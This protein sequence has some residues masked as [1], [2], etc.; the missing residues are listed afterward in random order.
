[1]D[2]GT[3]QLIQYTARQNELL[4]EQNELM[5]QEIN[6]MKQQHSVM[7][8][9]L[10]FFVSVDRR[11]QGQESEMAQEYLLELEKDGFHPSTG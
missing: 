4:T 9:L 6:I 11:E 7:Q 2:Q 10:N 1:M 8:E 3:H 5:K